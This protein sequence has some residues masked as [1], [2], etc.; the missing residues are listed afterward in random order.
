[1]DSVQCGDHLGGFKRIVNSGGNKEAAEDVGKFIL[2]H[3]GSPKP[4]IDPD[5]KLHMSLNC[6]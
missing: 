5:G 1:M 3:G 2:S 4:I 6:Q